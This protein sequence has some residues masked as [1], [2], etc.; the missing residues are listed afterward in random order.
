M[1]LNNRKVRQRLKPVITSNI[2]TGTDIGSLDFLCMLY[3]MASVF[4]H[5]RSLC[6]SQQ[7]LQAHTFH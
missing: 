5:S 1:C 2:T 7:F 6:V 3:D 4:L